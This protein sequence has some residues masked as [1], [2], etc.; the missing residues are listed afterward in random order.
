M[1]FDTHAHLCLC[2]EEISITEHLKTAELQGVKGVLDAGLHPD[3]FVKRQK[4]FHGLEN[5]FLGAAYA[6]SEE[7]VFPK[8]AMITLETILKTSK[9]HAICEIGLEYYRYKHNWKVQ[10]AVFAHQLKLAKEYDLPVFCHIREAFG[11][12][13]ALIQASSVKRGAVHCFTGGVE[14]AYRFIDLGFYLS[15]SGMV[16]F[17][18]SHSLRE[19]VKS[20]PMDKILTETDAP[21]LAPAPMRG[22]SNRLWYI[23]HTNRV[24]A[25]LKGISL[26]TCNAILL[27]NAMTLLHGEGKRSS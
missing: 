8:K 7:S 14:E 5:V 23:Q 12:A 15:F 17:G 6:P 1:Y 16:T 21:Y 20:I 26:E 10:Q 27:E 11:D 19:V 24:I 4:A 25:Q 3:D 22:E 18:R 9:P 2:E 13:C